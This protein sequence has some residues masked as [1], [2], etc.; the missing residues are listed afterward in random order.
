MRAGLLALVVAA[1]LP[2]A[3]RAQDDVGLPLGSTI[4]AAQVQDL[5]GREVDLAQLVGKKPVLVEFWATWCPI[6]TKRW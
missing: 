3:A 1:A 4:P 5:D 2:A 6:C